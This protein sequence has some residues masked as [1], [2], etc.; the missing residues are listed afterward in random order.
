[1]SEYLT[2][3]KILEEQTDPTSVILDVSIRTI[4][5]LS[6]SISQEFQNLVQ[7]WAVTP[8]NHDQKSPYDT[9]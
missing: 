3:V 9:T 1:M 6:I 5:C 2:H 4:L 8:F 7:V